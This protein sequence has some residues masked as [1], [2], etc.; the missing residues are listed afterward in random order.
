MVRNGAQLPPEVDALVERIADELSLYFQVRKG[1]KA[2]SG[3]AAR[4]G[5]PLASWQW[6]ACQ[7]QRSF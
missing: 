3:P 4:L 2:L 6:L 7:G 5:V 1:E